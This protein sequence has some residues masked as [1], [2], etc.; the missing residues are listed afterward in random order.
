MV[1]LD[2]NLNNVNVARRTSHL[3]RQLL[4]A[5]KDEVLEGVREAVVIVG[6]GG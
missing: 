6:L 3:V 2:N 4:A 1:Q 5:Q